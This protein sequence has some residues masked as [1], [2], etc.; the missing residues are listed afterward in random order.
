MVSQRRKKN[1]N[2]LK[3]KIVHSDRKSIG[4][5][6]FTRTDGEG[7]PMTSSSYYINAHMG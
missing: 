4:I 7:K 1:M 5:S 3:E 2:E 6:I